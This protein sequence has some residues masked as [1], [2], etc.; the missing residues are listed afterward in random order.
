VGGNCNPDVY[1]GE[2]LR[3]AVPWREAAIR[4]RKSKGGINAKEKSHS[5][6]NAPR[7]LFAARAV[8]NSAVAAHCII[9]III[10]Y[11]AVQRC[12]GERLGNNAYEEEIY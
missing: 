12:G 2:G 11:S 7:R 10:V 1:S 9:Y 4:N 5:A 6:L 3:R 8:R